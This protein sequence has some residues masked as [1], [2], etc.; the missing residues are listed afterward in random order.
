MKNKKTTNTKTSCRVI[1][2]TLLFVVAAIMFGAITICGVNQLNLY[3]RN[4]VGVSDAP[5][6]CYNEELYE[7]NNGTVIQ[8]TYPCVSNGTEEDTS[9]R[10]HTMFLYDRVSFTSTV[11]GQEL[12]IFTVIV[13]CLLTTA[14]VL[15]GV[16]YWN[17]N[18]A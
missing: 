6:L 13:G 17:H 8:D 15:G 11:L 4:L 2:N 7:K 3:N 5:A 10:D 16:I 12:M 14:S 9:L 18:R 1:F